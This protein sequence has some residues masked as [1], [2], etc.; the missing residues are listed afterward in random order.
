[1]QKNMGNIDRA[2][3]A[4]LVAPAA[5]VAGILVGAG[6]VAGIVLFVVAAVMIGT[7]AYGYC[8]LYAV[9]HFGTRR[10]TLPHA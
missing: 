6:S 1:M 5:I 2:I 9:F 10:Q 3:R 7:A 4:F 8:P